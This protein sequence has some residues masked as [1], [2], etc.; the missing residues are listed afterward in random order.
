M[1]AYFVTATGT[2]I[3]KTFLTSGL[4]RHLREQGHQAQ[5]FKPV[6]SG[7]D[8]PQGSDSALILEAM[9]LEA[10]EAAVADISPFRFKAPLSPDMAASREGREIDFPALISYCRAAAARDGT[11]LI[12]GV[13]GVMVPFDDS[14]TTLDLM[15]EL[16]LPVV[17][18]AGSYL[19]TI[20]H[21]LTAA[22]VLLRAG[23]VI[24]AIVINDTGTN[25]VLLA[26][27]VATLRRFLPGQV[28]V[29][30][31]RDPCSADFAPVAAALFREKTAPGDAADRE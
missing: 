20:S 7:Y 24:Q 5:G 31:P 12:E 6:I 8:G 14:R 18:V 23:L 19:G 15:A 28:I 10:T 29:S 27:T 16:A 13:G 21:A 3:G 4:L 9:G 1:S 17:L 26:D 25:E 2:G 22:A 30:L 11:V